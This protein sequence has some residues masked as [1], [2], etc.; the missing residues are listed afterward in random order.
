MPAQHKNKKPRPLLEKG[1]F[2]FNE[3]AVFA[4]ITA[5]V[6]VTLIVG[7]TLVKLYLLK[8]IFPPK[9]D[10]SAIFLSE[11]VLPTLTPRF[12]AGGRQTYSVQTKGRGPNITDLILDPIDPLPNQLQ[13]IGVGVQSDSPV[14][15]VYYHLKTDNKTTQ[16]S[17]KLTQGTTTDG[18]WSTSVILDDSYL[19]TYMAII[20]AENSKG[21]TKVEPVYR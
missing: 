5:F 14:K 12:L 2:S 16:H 3:I 17:L 18:F 11:P 7:I 19:Y 9:T 4:V 10:K 8:F 6:G 20:E 21:I 1:E 13:F 15:Y